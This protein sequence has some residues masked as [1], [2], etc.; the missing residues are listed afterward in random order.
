MDT[1]QRIKQIR[2][3]V[4]QLPNDHNKHVLNRITDLL[5]HITRTDKSN[6]NTANQK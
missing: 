2:Q 5:E 6:Q 4:S 1:P 3:L